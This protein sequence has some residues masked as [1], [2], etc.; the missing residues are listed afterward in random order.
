MLHRSTLV[1]ALLGAASATLGC[2]ANLDDAGGDP[3]GGKADGASAACARQHIEWLLQ[4]FRPALEAAPLDPARVTQ[5]KALAQ[6]APCR[7][8]IVGPGAW[9]TW[10]DLTG[11]HVLAPYFQQH[12][13]A[14]T[15]LLQPGTAAYHDHDRFADATRP[16]PEVLAAWD[17]MQAAAPIVVADHL[18]MSE[19]TGRYLVHAE[20]VYAPL[21]TAAGNEVVEPTWALT[22]GEAQFL[23]L[24]AQSQPRQGQDGAYAA[25]VELFGNTLADGFTVDDSDD[26]N[27]FVPDAGCREGEPAPCGRVAALTRLASLAPSARGPLDSAAW[28]HVLALWAMTTPAEGD[29]AEPGYLD[30]LRWV[31]RARPTTLS[32]L[33]AYQTWL[34]AVADTDH[35]GVLTRSVLPARPCTDAAADDDAARAHEA[36]LAANPGLA[37]NLRSATAPIRCR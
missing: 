15:A 19:W 34:E 27:A 2:V 11:V 26:F 35:A 5:L 20:Q 8:E 10:F 17:V 29:L 31:D 22:A 23:G 6:E 21:R 18:A 9:T 28:M 14:A 12:A 37:A 3:A 25:W 7:G 1:I 24:L 13:A 16:A 30:Q 33:G 36:F 4:S 32:G